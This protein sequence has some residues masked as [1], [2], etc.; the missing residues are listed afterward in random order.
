MNTIDIII[1]V[2]IGL[3]VLGVIVAVASVKFNKAGKI[4]EDLINK[5]LEDPYSITGDS[6][7]EGG[8]KYDDSHSAKERVNNRETGKHLSSDF[9]IN[10]C[11]NIFA[12]F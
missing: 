11:I 4:E 8:F 3:A 1:Y 12:V 10:K 9:S 7:K 6:V 2:V 5:T